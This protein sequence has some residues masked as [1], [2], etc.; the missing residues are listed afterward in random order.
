LD[1]LR[2]RENAL[3]ESEWSPYAL[4]FLRIVAGV[5]FMPHGIEKI[6]GTRVLDP[7]RQVAS[8]LE[9][10]C[11]PLLALGLFTR[12]IAFLLS[13]EM[14][15]AYFVAWAPLGFWQ[16]FRTFGMEASILNSFLF[17]FIWAAGPGAWSLDGLLRRKREQAHA[18]PR[19]NVQAERP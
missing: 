16:S 6:F 18:T 9:T 4:G 8:V 15:V 10:V 7:L 13:G 3:A 19:Y 2:N 14:A 5:L 1:Y 17:L 11:G 12:P